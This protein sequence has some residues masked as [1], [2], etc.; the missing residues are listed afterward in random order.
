M[1]QILEDADI[2]DKTIYRRQKIAPLRL[3]YMP[4]MCVDILHAHCNVTFNMRKGV[5][6]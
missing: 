6:E 4:L 1:T 3:L 2:A 5:N